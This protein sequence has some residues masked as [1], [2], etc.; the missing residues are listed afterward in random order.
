MRKPDLSYLSGPPKFV[1]HVNKEDNL[2]RIVFICLLTESLVGVGGGVEL[3]QLLKERM[4]SLSLQS[5][6]A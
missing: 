5:R 3:G 1:H 6:L 4:C 2:K